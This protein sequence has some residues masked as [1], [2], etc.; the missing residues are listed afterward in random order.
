MAEYWL[1]IAD[2]GYWARSDSRL[3]WAWRLA[4]LRAE[5][6]DFAG[7]VELAGRL[8]GLLDEPSS[9]GAGTGGGSVFGTYVAVRPTLE[10]EMV[11]QVLDLAPTIDW[12]ER[13]A[14]A[15][16][17]CARLAP[18]VGDALTPC[19]LDSTP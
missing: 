7:A 16:S 11:P 9:F 3:R 15:R 17:W 10:S 19:P 4:E 1:G 18:T 14:T 13:L 2:L 5:R 12:P 8:R 6:G